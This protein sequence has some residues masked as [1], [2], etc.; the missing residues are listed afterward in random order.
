MHTYL[1][2]KQHS[3]IVAIR[4]GLML[5]TQIK[6]QKLPIVSRG[7]K[8]RHVAYIIPMEGSMHTRHGHDHESITY[9]SQVEV[10]LVFYVKE[11]ALVA[12]NS[13]AKLA[14]K[15]GVKLYA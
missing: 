5:L 8:A 13:R 1:A 2:K 10:E 4:I 7:K 12:G 11:T 14:R 3:I 9:I 15:F 6:H